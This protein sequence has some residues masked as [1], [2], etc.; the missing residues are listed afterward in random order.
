MAAPLR[1]ALTV[2]IALLAMAITASAHDKGPERV[3]PSVGTIG[4]LQQASR[5][6]AATLGGRLDAGHDWLYRRLQHFFEDVDLRFAVPEQAPIV[7]P[8]S[9]VRIGFESEFV[10]RKNGMDV[11]ARPEFEATL[12]LPNIEQRLG[13]FATSADLPESPG[14]PVDEPNPL[15]VGARFLPGSY[16]DVEFGVQANSS[17]SAFAA[18]RWAPE[19]DAGALRVYPFI[20][21]YVQSGLGVGTSGGIA[22]EHWSGRWIV[23]SASYGNWVRN[24]AV[25][26]WSQSLIIGYAAGVIQERRYDRFATGRD[27]ACGVAVRVSVSGG[28]ASK[29]SL[30]EA[31]VFMKRPLHGGW[32]FGYVEPVVQWNRDFGWHPDVGVRI[33]VDALFWGL[34]SLPGEV[35]TYCAHSFLP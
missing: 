31:S 34:A 35:A 22:F 14:T 27:L 15:R 1:K 17:P 3:R 19:F 11:L 9:P 5:A 2:L 20:K 13:V 12:R 7:V 6:A 8:L 33:G 10:H 30:F 16:V 26:A 18:L 25:T 29:T 4:K 32:L 23:R 28:R 21:T 24:T